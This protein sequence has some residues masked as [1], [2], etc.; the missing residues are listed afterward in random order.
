MTATDASWNVILPWYAPRA[1]VALDSFAFVSEN[2]ID[3]EAAER[4]DAI[5]ANFGA[6]PDAA[7]DDYTGVALIGDGHL[8]W[9]IPDTVMQRLERARIAF[10]L[11]QLAEIDPF[12]DITGFVNAN[13][14]DLYT[15]N[16]IGEAGRL[17]SSFIQMYRRIDVHVG[18]EADIKI[19]RDPLLTGISATR[20]NERPDGAL[21]VAG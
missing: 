3:G 1:R 2:E 13:A 12:A 19:V 6:R 21:H 17:S 5:A 10:A 7:I 15:C 8:Q 9:A 16:A 11:S 20:P 4:M 14:F 18:R